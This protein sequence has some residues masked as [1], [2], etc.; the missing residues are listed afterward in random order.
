M[1]LPLP[2]CQFGSSDGGHVSAD[3]FAIPR[4]DQGIISS[5]GH[6]LTRFITNAA[7]YTNQLGDTVISVEVAAWVKTCASDISSEIA[8]K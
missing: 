6:G 1:L 8:Q 3:A 2:S 5:I 7:A 4:V